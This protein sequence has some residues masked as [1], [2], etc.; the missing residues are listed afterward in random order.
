MSDD[1]A[2]N[3][4]PTDLV[5]V[6]L[7]RFVNVPTAANMMLTCRAWKEHIY[8]CAWFWKHWCLVLG[9]R[10]T[11]RQ[12]LSKT[13]KFCMQTVLNGFRFDEER[14]LDALWHYIFSPRSQD[15]HV[16]YPCWLITCM[17]SCVEMTPIGNIIYLASAQKR[18][19]DVRHELNCGDDG[20]LSFEFKH[21]FMFE[22]KREFMY[23]DVVKIVIRCDSVRVGAE[24]DD[25]V[26]S[27]SIVEFSFL[28]QHYM[29]CVAHWD[30]QVLKEIL[31]T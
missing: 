17:L 7:L 24:F 1:G 5:L 3:Q 18:W 4:F 30:A 20:V 8:Q 26:F 27:K 13:R 19:R 15:P 25:V 14:D 10:V 11:Q 12:T 29:Q 16:R 22:F 6:L 28:V 21:E 2:R 31:K 23:A 9:G